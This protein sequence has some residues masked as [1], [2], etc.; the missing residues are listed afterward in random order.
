VL[1]LELVD[2]SS[3]LPLPDEKDLH[4]MGQTARSTPARV[5]V[6][7]DD[8]AIR[9]TLRYVL[10]D[11]GYDVDEAPD[12]LA[13]LETLRASTA[14]RVVL[15]DLMMPRLD[16]VGVLHAVAREPRLATTNAYVV[17]T[18]N[19]WRLDTQDHIFSSLDVPVIPKPFDMDALLRTIASA[20]RR[21]IVH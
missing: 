21:I 11:E 1:E 10:E 18:A 3:Y 4:L 5:L 6:V 19:R 17:I 14:P 8:R 13:A 9:E 16:G 7:D 15:L 2:M 20:A 12:G